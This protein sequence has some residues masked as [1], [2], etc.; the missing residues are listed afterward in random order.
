MG[1]LQDYKENRA[2]KKEEKRK[3]KIEK[4][5]REANTNNYLHPITGYEYTGSF[6]KANGRFGR[7][8]KLYNHYGL[9]RNNPF[10]WFVNVLPE[11][12]SEGVRAY[13][14]EKSKPLTEK[15][16]NQVVSKIST[17]QSALDNEENDSK[18]EDDGNI[19]IKMMQSN[20][21][22]EAVR[23]DKKKDIAIDSEIRVLFT[24]ENPDKINKEIKDLNHIYKTDINGLQMISSAGD[25][26]NLFKNLLE[27]PTGNKLDHC[28][29]SK[30]YAGFDHAIRKGLDDDKGVPIGKLHASLSGGIAMM[31][32]NG[33]F[34]DRIIVASQKT[35]NIHLYDRKLSASSLWGQKIANHAMC[36]GHKTFHI[37]LNKFRYEAN[38]DGEGHFSCSPIVNN[39]LEHIDLSK[40]G[41]N[42]LE[43]FGDKKDLTEIYETNLGKIAHIFYLI[44]NRT[45]T[46]QMKTELQKQ[47]GVFYE[48][49]K[50]WDKQAELYPERTRV[51]NI[52]NHETYPRFADFLTRLSN[53][54]KSVRD[55]GTDSEVD[56]AKY[57]RDI[58]ERILGSHYATFNRH[59]TLPDFTDPNK[60][61]YYYELGRLST[62]PSIQEA[63]FLNSFDY[64][65]HAC[66]E[67]D[68]IMI[69]GVDKISVETLEY[70]K[71][72]IAKLEEKGIRIAYLFDN[73][74]NGEVKDKSKR[75]TYVEYAD[76]FNTE[77]VLYTNF[78][79][80][81]DYSILGTMAPNDFEKY[82]DLIRQQLPED[83]KDLLVADEDIQYLIRRKGDLTSNFV[84][85]DMV[86]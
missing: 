14:I 60:F 8:L 51:L 59:T 64:I 76:V 36:N 10:G 41:L 61:Q 11:V 83:L 40:G 33:S 25:Q 65:A 28:M 75:E 37:V 12:S 82:Q 18:N 49:M 52:K 22:A 57:L 17:T 63:Q 69:H 2:N 85:A 73:I 56:R 53:F 77:G 3:K 9:N 5:K 48:S 66:M 42:P 70:I 6:I 86:L 78:E 20:D 29:M 26:E 80:Q 47:L 67:N 58:V 43:M 68:I 15:E 50:M 35:S 46:N 62:N 71:P 16:Q 27:P 74:G 30:Y 55:K 7:V 81:F 72:R 21:L 84:W 24:G 31:D 34:K 39:V 4:Q 38:E 1:I 32:L 23:E 13:F 44:S 54:E 45:L 79:T 19:T